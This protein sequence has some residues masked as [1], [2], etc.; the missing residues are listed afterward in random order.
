MK[1]KFVFFLLFTA[2]VILFSL[3]NATPTKLRFIVWEF[4]ASQ[5]LVIFLSALGG[6]VI[7]MVVSAL[8]GRRSTPET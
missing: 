5:A 8:G 6:A 3:Q 4:T 1:I 7:G 2:V